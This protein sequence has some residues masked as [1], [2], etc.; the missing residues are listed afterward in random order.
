MK[1]DATEKQLMDWIAE[2]RSQ[3]LRVS[4]NIIQKGSTKILSFMECSDMEDSDNFLV[5]DGGLR[6][7]M[8]RNRLSLRKSTTIIAK[9]LMRTSTFYPL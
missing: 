3:S 1:H 8:N 4:Q 5:S 9:K 2:Q 7:F 6:R